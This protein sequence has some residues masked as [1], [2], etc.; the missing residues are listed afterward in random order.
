MLKRV[1]DVSSTA[2]LLIGCSNKQGSCS[3]DQLPCSSLSLDDACYCLVR[4]NHLPCLASQGMFQNLFGAPSCI[5]QGLSCLTRRNPFAPHSCFSLP[6][7][8]ATPK[9]L[10]CCS[11]KAPPSMHLIALHLIIAHNTMCLVLSH[12]VIT[13]THKCFGTRSN[14]VSRML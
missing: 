13:F 2:C 4:G 1:H 14:N 11:L 12:R 5:D 9:T 7:H 6:H 8:Q 10:L 3:N